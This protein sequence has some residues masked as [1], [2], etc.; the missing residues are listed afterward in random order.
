MFSVASPLHYRWYTQPQFIFALR[1]KNIKNDIIIASWF[2]MVHR[3]IKV[4]AEKKTN[5]RTGYKCNDKI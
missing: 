5:A 3:N 1:R 2:K 4:N